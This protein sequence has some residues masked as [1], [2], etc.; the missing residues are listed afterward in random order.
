MTFHITNNIGAVNEQLIDMR[1]ATK[2][3]VELE[4]R[5]VKYYIGKVI[6]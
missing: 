3:M 4:K 2:Y 6:Q 1:K 5:N